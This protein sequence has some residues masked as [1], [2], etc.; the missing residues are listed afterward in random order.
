MY[1]MIILSFKSTQQVRLYSKRHCLLVPSSVFQLANVNV[2]KQM[3]LLAAIYLTNALLYV[4][5]ESHFLL[6]YVCRELHQPYTFAYT[7][8]CLAYSQQQFDGNI[9]ERTLTWRYVITSSIILVFLLTETNQF[10]S[11]SYTSVLYVLFSVDCVDIK[12]TLSASREKFN[13][14]SCS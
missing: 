1:C 8:G 9:Y 13:Q 6:Y 7:L 10:S 2:Q 12:C 3:T 11:Q 4:C 14:F 5:Y